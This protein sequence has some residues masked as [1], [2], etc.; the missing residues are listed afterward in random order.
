MG[1]TVTKRK[2]FNIRND[3]QY[4]VYVVLVQ[5]TLKKT[6][7]D[8]L[9]M[10]NETL[11]RILSDEVEEQRNRIV[12]E[13]IPEKFGFKEIPA[14]SFYGWFQPGLILTSQTW[15]YYGKKD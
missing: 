8:M 10:L 15:F 12:F 5:G 7:G 1:N 9:P 3:T 11:G 4:P 2:Q 14:G 13:M 6:V